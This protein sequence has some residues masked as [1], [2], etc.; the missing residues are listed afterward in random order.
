MIFMIQTNTKQALLF[1][2]T[3]EQYPL[4]CV[5]VYNFVSPSKSLFLPQP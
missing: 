4:E 2:A 3:A 5:F 1:Y